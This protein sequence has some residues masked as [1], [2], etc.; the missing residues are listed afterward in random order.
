MAGWVDVAGQRAVQTVPGQL[1]AVPGSGQLGADGLWAK[2]VQ[3]GTAVVLL[4]ADRVSGVVYPP[5]VVADEDAPAHWGQL[6][7]RAV[8]AGLRVSRVRGVVSDG[9][10]GLAQRVEERLWWVHHQRCVF[11]RWRNL[12]R[13]LRE[14]A[15]VAASGLRGAAATA[16]KQATRR[17]LAGLAHA[18]LD[19][20]DDAAAV[21][22]LRTLAADA[23][24]GALAQGLRNVL[25]QALVY[26]GPVNQGLGRVAPEWSWW[27]FRVRLSRGRNHRTRA[28]L[29]RAAVRW[30][31]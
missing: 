23:R 28:R 17:T 9:A 8:R 24:G 21:A 1:A 15:T 18:V 3:N 26:Q 19:A 29:E 10:R 2:L 27:D 30:A 12:A 16:V 14:A 22:A 31:T 5:V 13:P 11:H 7:Q 6:V 25:E 4:L 20:P